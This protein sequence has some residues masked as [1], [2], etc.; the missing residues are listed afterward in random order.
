ML[1]GAS[2]KG[3]CLLEFVDR[4]MLE[5]QLK[6]L[7]RLMHADFLPGEDNVF[8]ELNTQISEYFEGQRKKFT[9]PL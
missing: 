6:R 5:T 1:A 9:L 7:E 3:V 4:R 8:K 2:D